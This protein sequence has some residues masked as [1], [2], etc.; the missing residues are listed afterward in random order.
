MEAG[1]GGMA[2][3]ATVV[4]GTSVEGIAPVG[5]GNTVLLCV[6]AKGCSAEA[7]SGSA[8]RAAEAEAWTEDKDV[9]WTLASVV[10]A[11]PWR[12]VA[13]LRVALA[14]RSSCLRS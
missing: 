12:V 11:A 8:R 3:W 5:S 2:V 13:G 14:N 9:A 6:V 1:G 4:G 7:W 10:T